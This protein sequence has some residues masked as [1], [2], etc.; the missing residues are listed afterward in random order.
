MGRLLLGIIAAIVALVVVGVVA[1]KLIGAL[2][3][4]FFY[5]LVGAAV[6]G[7]G[8]FLYYR[9]KRALGPGT[10]AR[11]RLDA[12]SWTYRQRNR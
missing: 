7:G 11:N 5:L 9:A 3:G 8:A 12:A 6:V 4:V 2:M 10:R 1:I